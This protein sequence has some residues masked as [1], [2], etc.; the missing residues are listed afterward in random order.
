MD[1]KIITL[2]FAGVLTFGLVLLMVIFGSGETSK[3]EISTDGVKREGAFY[4]G[5]KEAK[6]ELVEFSDFQC[7]ACAVNA[8]E[9][10]KVIKEYGDKIVFYYRHYPLPQHKFATNAAKA[11]EAAG[12]QGKFWEMHD[13]IFQN[14]ASLTN[15]SFVTLA[16]QLQ[17]DMNKFNSDFNGLETSRI[18]ETDKKDAVKLGVS[19]T[20]TFYLNGEKVQGG[21]Q[22]F[23]DWK[24]IIDAKLAE[25]PKP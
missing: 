6:I 13:I 19:S 14:Q 20:P 2:I 18:V 21:G 22:S 7:P 12:K 24:K 8:N 15:E 25:N 9:V 5:N 10:N 23:E 4:K 3:K 11:A 16:N 1:K 17:L